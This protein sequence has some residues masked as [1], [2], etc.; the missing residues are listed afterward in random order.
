M[1]QKQEA[2]LTPKDFTVRKNSCCAGNPVSMMLS[3]SSSS[4]SL[5][6]RMS[7]VTN[8]TLGP[9]DALSNRLNY[10]IYHLP[11]IVSKPKIKFNIQLWAA[12]IRK[13]GGLL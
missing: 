4:T 1:K 10:D 6:G 3:L 12:K 5:T 9:Y 11:T 13:E 2:L 7:S 8:A